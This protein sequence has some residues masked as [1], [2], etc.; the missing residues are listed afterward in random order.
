MK[1]C[2]K[3]GRKFQDSEDTDHGFIGMNNRRS[4]CN[5]EIIKVETP[6]HPTHDNDPHAWYDR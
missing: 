2:N 4:K 6:E 5:G 1:Q 3:C